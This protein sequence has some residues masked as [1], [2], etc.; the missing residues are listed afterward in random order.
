MEYQVQK[1]NKYILPQAVY[2]RTIWTIRDYYRIKQETD[3]MLGLSAISMDGMPHGSNI[4]SEVE[5]KAIK[6]EESVNTIKAIEKELKRIPEGYRE[7]VWNN[8]VKR[9]KY[10][11]DADRTTYARYKS[12]LIYGVAKALYYI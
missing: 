12:R 5:N 9:E 1:N 10:P 8:I 2:N 3:S 7:G 4:G 6:R 11:A